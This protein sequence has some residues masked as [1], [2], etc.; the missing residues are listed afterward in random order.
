LGAYFIPLT[1]L[2]YYYGFG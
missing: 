2:K 1:V